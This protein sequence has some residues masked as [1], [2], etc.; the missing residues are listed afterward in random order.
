[1][2]KITRQRRTITLKKSFGYKKLFVCNLEFLP[3]VK[4]PY[5]FSQI[6][7]FYCYNSNSSV[8]CFILELE[9]WAGKAE[10]VG[11]CSKRPA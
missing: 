7:N 1:M 8:L 3:S 11:N 6:D 5:F 9:D 10:F 4:I 2:W